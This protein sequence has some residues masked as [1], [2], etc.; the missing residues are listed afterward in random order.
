MLEAL[1]L[2]PLDQPAL[3]RTLHPF[4][5]AE[6]KEYIEFRLARSGMPEQTISPRKRCRRF[7]I[8]PAG[9][10]PRFTNCASSFCWLPFRP[11]PKF[12]RQNFS[13][14]SSMSRTDKHQRSWRL[15]QPWCW[16]PASIL[17]AVMSIPC[18]IHSHAD[19]AATTDSR[20]DTPWAKAGSGNKERTVGSTVERSPACTSQRKLS[21]SSRRISHGF[22]HA[23]AS[24][25][26]RKGEL[27]YVSSGSSGLILDRQVVDRVH[28]FH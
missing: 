1:N 10:R 23:D 24:C 17:L 18:R 13:I 12:A 11:H 3:S 28:R 26:R 6:T 22:G 5:A 9:W 15:P 8:R 19:R 2:E 16:S 25:E 21:T 4:T 14:K 20:P 27:G 7:T